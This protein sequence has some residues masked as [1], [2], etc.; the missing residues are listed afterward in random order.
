M[1]KLGK[2][3]IAICLIIGFVCFF[4]NVGN[5]ETIKGVIYLLI[6]I[7]IAIMI[8]TIAL[9]VAKGYNGFLAFLLGLFIPLLGSL[10]VI[11]LLPDQSVS[12][13]RQTSNDSWQTP[14]DTPPVYLTYKNHQHQ[15]KICCN[16][17]MKVKDD[18]S[19]CP[20]CGSESFK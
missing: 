18:I 20:K 16:C 12:D 9:A 6:F 17:G 8:A 1:G 5:K 4:Y 11:A 14:N 7:Q 15:V 13:F 19:V 10:I 2:V 3:L